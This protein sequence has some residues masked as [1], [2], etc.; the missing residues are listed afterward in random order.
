MINFR[1]ESEANRMD[2]FDT[3]LDD[4]SKYFGFEDEE[5]PDYE[6]YKNKRKKK[7]EDWFEGYSNKH[8]D[9][10]KSLNQEIREHLAKPTRL[11]PTSGQSLSRGASG[12]RRSGNS[13][14]AQ[15]SS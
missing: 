12:T 2:R 6:A 1:L 14:G 4:M 10:A 8:K 3:V 15:T 11:S 5:E 7:F 13:S 9:H